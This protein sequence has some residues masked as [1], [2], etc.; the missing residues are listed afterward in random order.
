MELTAPL[1]ALVEEVL[2][3]IPKLIAALVTFGAS[4]LVSVIA[5]RWVRRTASASID[6]EETVILLSRLTR[7]AV[8]AAGTVLALDQVD[9][10]VT[11]F[12]AGLGIAGLTI[13]FALQD[14]TRNFI[15][16]LILLV[17]QPFEIGDAVEAADHSGTVLS[18]T[19]RDT[20]LKTWDGETV[21]LPNL[22]VFSKPIINYSAL[23]HR[24]RTVRIGL[25]YEEDVEWAS[26][27]FLAALGSVD[28]V[29]AEP[30][31]T[32]H[33]MDLG[34]SALG[35]DA[36]F[37]VNQETHGL[38]DVHSSVVRTIKVVSE[39]EGIELPYPI[40]TVRLEGPQP[41]I[42]QNLEKGTKQR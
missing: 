30:A 5:A 2:R 10:D 17:R 29:L 33:A 19:T 24:R 41:E 22:E 14:I 4:L 25:G 38:F 20:V 34:D 42:G 11:G 16:G 28:G 9:F 37:W 3:F 35:L 27:V 1:Q 36:R 15:A 18:V 26:E 13:G 6:D 8:I 31:P 21:I 7:W 23:P 32:V 40:Q 12:V 39:R